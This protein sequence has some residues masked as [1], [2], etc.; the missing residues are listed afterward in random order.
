M[1]P[2]NPAEQLQGNLIHTAHEFYE[3]AQ[4][5][6]ITADTHARLMRLHAFAGELLAATKPS[7]SKQQRPA[8]WGKPCG[9]CLA[10]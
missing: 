6:P 3:L 5:D 4:I 9:P 7:P 2:L 8:W 10:S 1:T